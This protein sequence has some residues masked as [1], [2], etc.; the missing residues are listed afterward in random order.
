[1]VKETDM[2][3]RDFVFTIIGGLIV[4]VFQQFY[5]N[6]RE[7]KRERE[8]KIVKPPNTEKVLPQDIFQHLGPGGTVTLMREMLGSPNRYS[9]K[10]SAVFLDEEV[11][12]NSYLYNFKNGYLKITS[13]DNETID[14][15]TV[16]PTDSSIWVPSLSPVGD[17]DDTELGKIGEATVS[18]ELIDIT[19]KHRF[20]Q[21]RVDSTFAIHYYTGYPLYL[22]HTY[23]GFGINK[24]EEYLKTGDVSVFKDIVIDSVCVSSSEDAVFYIYDMEP[25]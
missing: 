13:K 19:Q 7:G 16:K 22:D 20:I 9:K 1:M 24:R 2:N 21:T 17:D 14:S 3:L 25:L 6:R 10:D 11:E 8:A 4:W 23:F 15:I 5:L 12:T 18:K